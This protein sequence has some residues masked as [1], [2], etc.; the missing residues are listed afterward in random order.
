M[1][2][3]QPLNIIPKLNI[4]LN[5]ATLDSAHTL[6]R[7]WSDTKTKTKWELIMSAFMLVSG[8]GK[9]GNIDLCSVHARAHA[10]THTHT[11]TF[12]ILY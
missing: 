11:H 9:I 5:S 7:D 3:A 2:L 10:R 1:I 12:Y 6:V 4:T 8:L